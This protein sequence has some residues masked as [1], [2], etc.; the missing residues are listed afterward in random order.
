MPGCAPRSPAES[1]PGELRCAWPHCLRKQRPWL[2]AE[3]LRQRLEGY[4]FLVANTLSLIREVS[5]LISLE[6][7]R[8]L[9]PESRRRLSLVQRIRSPDNYKLIIS[10]NLYR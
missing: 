6:Q 8:G 1:G 4:S 10:I 9:A 2:A 5:K 7:R 3:Q